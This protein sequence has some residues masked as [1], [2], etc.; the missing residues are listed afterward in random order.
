MSA[1]KLTETVSETECQ[2]RLE[3]QDRMNNEF[4]RAL[5]NIKVALNGQPGDTSRPGLAG[6]FIRM[7]D[8]IDSCNEKLDSL[9]DK[10]ILLES[11]DIVGSI[12]AINER[13]DSNEESIKEAIKEAKRTQWGKVI[14]TSLSTAAACLTL[15]TAAYMLRVKLEETP[16][17]PVTHA[18]PAKTNTPRRTDW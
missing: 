6:G 14:I 15:S 3:S 2:A 18:N 5:S 12:R 9:N 16:K 8:K 7:S 11:K 17:P 10:L 4:G 13:V 1:S